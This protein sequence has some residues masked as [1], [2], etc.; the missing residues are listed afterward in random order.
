MFLTTT[1]QSK[2]QT[3]RGSKNASLQ[4]CP[5]ARIRR[6][7]GCSSLRVRPD[8]WSTQHNWKTTPENAPPGYHLFNDANAAAQRKDYAKACENFCDAAEVGHPQ[9]K[10][11]CIDYAYLAA[12]RIE[13]GGLRYVC[14]ASQFDKKQTTSVVDTTNHCSIRHLNVNN[15]WENFALTSKRNW[16]KTSQKQI[17]QGGFGEFTA[18]EF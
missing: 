11:K 3:R 18:E 13:I 5:F 9:A 2:H 12:T 8:Q 10:Q 1:W 16:Q 15:S 4:I 7:C 14:N 6:C 17:Q